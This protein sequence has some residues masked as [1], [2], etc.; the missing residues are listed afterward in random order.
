[1]DH[2]ISTLTSVWAP[3]GINLYI[4]LLI[5][6]QDDKYKEVWAAGFSTEIPSQHFTTWL[7]QPSLKDLGRI[8]I[9]GFI[10]ELNTLARPAAK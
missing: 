2:R 10:K 6:P 3:R 7:M 4:T 5:D 8:D 9:I 1:M